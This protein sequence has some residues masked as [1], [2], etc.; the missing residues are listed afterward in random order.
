ME[1]HGTWTKDEEGYM[2][3]ETSELQ[4]YYEAVTDKYNHV[5]NRYLDETDDEDDA[6]YK[7]LQDGYEMVTDY[8]LID[9]KNEFA[10]TYI[11][12]A[13]VIEIW[14]EFDEITEKRI[15]DKGFIRISSK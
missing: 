5:Y 7:A 15:F 12:P 3:F 8:K 1:I 10:T 2:E 14:Y 13:Y 4:R 11:T 9:G 6:Y